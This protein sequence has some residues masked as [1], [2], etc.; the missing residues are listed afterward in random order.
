MC[1]IAG[2]VG[3]A[4]SQNE[5]REG[6]C[7]A[8]KA[9]RHRGPDDQ[10]F[11]VDAGVALGVSRLAIRDPVKGIQPISRQGLT[12]VFNG[13]L[14][15]TEHLKNRL[16]KL[17]YRFETGCDT[18]VLFN[19]FLECGPS[20][21]P[22]LVGMFA[23][24]VWDSHHK[25][26]YLARDR[27]GEKPLYYTY[28]EGFLA[29]ASEI[30]GLRVWPHIAWDM[31]LEDINVFLKNSY[32]PHPRTGW[33]QIFK[34]E[35]GSFLTWHEG[36]VVKKHYFSVHL[37]NKRTSENGEELFQL[38]DESVKQCAVSDRPVGAFLSGGI[39]STTIAYFLSKHRPDAPVFSIHWDDKGY[40]EEYYTKEAATVLGLNHFA[41]KCDE[42]F[43]INHFESIASLYDEPF[44]DESMIPTYCLANF[45]KNSVDVVL[46]G[47]GADELF[48]GYERYFFE[49]SDE[50]YLDVFSASSQETLQ[51]ICQSDF[52]A[53]DPKELLSSYYLQ[54]QSLI[55]DQRLRSIVDMKTYL[56]DDILMKV[57]RACMAVSLENRSPF[58]TPQVSDFAL[59]CTLKELIGNGKRGKEVLR[60][61]M[62]H[63]LPPSILERKKMGFGVP[64]QAW[65]RLS[66]KDWMMSRLLEGSLIKTGWVSKEG[67]KQLISNH[68]AKQGN[69]SRTIFNL[70]ALEVWLRAHKIDKLLIPKEVYY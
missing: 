30:K 44:A 63:H 45:A 56:T 29:F 65:F 54:T 64:L 55:S 46:T 31:S 43:F 15:D 10:R 59:K 40:S 19:A 28:G 53:F 9:L 2:F 51:L 52:L 61:A 50:K 27:W 3:S 70:L 20:I 34:L 39:D 23:F 38:L 16:L 1:G 12:L 49:G 47:D 17:G 26:L 4:L 5:L 18:E 33:N 13:E 11:Y 35:P 42:S 7:R 37:E 57:D 41:V 24:A 69:Y 25:T 14:Y 58:L 22:E 48:H 21:L 66:L 67:V 62:K 6:I 68:I 36:A 32:L 60:A 8:C